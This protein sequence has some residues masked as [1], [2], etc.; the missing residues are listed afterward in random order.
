MRCAAEDFGE[1]ELELVHISRR[2]REAKAVEALLTDANVDYVV[3]PDRYR[4]TF[5]FF[6]P[7][8]R[9]GAFFYVSR[10]DADVSRQLLASRG[11][12][13]FEDD[14]DEEPRDAEA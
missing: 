2:L 3:T 12:Q 13:V 7:T 11:Y 10:L 4:A 9:V 6:F 14:S 1:D 5:L 8:Q